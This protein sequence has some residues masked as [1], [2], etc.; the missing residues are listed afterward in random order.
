MKF[1][2]I[3]MC[4]LTLSSCVTLPINSA[5][6]AED[7]HLSKKTVTAKI[8]PFVD[9]RQDLNTSSS[10]ACTIETLIPL[11]PYCT[12][13]H[14]N[15]AGR[16]DFEHF[17]ESM[18]FALAKDLRINSLFSKVI[19]DENEKADIYITAAV[20]EYSL[21]KRSTNYGVSFLGYIIGA[22]GAPMGW[23]RNGVSI[24]Y[25]LK[26]HQGQKLF[27]KTYTNH[28]SRVYGYYYPSIISLGASF[29]PINN[30]FFNDLSELVLEN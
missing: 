21:S 20:N 24:T 26:N 2:K 29:K 19:L 3:C 4:I 6:K 1:I 7:I 18:R 27:E 25:T 13:Y 28:V 12:K 16:S 5:Y 15:N 10:F 9:N 11:W 17:K 22:F 14:K 8:L 30:E 23:S